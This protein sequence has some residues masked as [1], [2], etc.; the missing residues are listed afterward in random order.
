MKDQK[1]KNG[2]SRSE[3]KGWD[4]YFTVETVL[5]FPFALYVCIFILYSGFYLYDRCV[6]Q[7]DA[8]RAALRGSSLYREDMQEVYNAAEDAMLEHMQNKYIA[9]DCVFSI[10]AHQGIK[11]VIEGDTEMPFRGLE[12]FAGTGEWHIKAQAESKCINPVF[13]IRTC[14]QLMKAK[15]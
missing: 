7:Q 15:E 4:A 6:A 10:R 3:R 13:V 12:L 11:V 5:V 1:R 9:S 8:Y 2:K 14:R